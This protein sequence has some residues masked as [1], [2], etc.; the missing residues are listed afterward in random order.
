MRYALE[1]E[2]IETYTYLPMKYSDQTIL[3]LPLQEKETRQQKTSQKSV[4]VVILFCLIVSGCFVQD[5]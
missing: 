2:D 3:P 4:F 1:W 5:M